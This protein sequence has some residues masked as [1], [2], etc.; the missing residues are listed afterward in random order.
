MT[1]L[2]LTSWAWILDMSQWA[3]SL[4]GAHYLIFLGGPHKRPLVEIWIKRRTKIV[5]IG[6]KKERRRIGVQPGQGNLPLLGKQAERHA[7]GL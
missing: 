4:L 1:I 7:L 5:P 2:Q 6:K 3:Q